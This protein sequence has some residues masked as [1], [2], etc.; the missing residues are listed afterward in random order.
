MRKNNTLVFLSLLLISNGIMGLSLPANAS[1]G[2]KLFQQ[3]CSRCHQS[4]D[5]IKTPPDQVG[6]KM[7]SGGIRQHRFNLDDTSLDSIV[8]YLKQQSK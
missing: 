4:A 1:D 8:E 2:A 6:A 7:R 3:Q 5:R